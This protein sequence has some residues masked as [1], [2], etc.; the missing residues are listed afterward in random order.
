MS[1][2][3]HPKNEVT[4]VDNVDHAMQEKDFGHPEVLSEKDIMDNAFEAE[5]REHDM[6]LWEA[7]KDHPVACFWAFIFCF[8]IVS[9]ALPG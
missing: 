1:S 2:G 6:G 8:T 5:K 7:V 9:L 4:H 3:A